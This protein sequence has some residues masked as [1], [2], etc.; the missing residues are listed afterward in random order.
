MEIMGRPAEMSSGM[1]LARTAVVER[2]TKREV[3]RVLM[4]MLVRLRFK[5]WEWSMEGFDGAFLLVEES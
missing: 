1:G 4:L 2:R 5:F 3:A